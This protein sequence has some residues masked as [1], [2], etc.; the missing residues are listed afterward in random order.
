M[1]INQNPPKVFWDENQQPTGFFG[2]L[3]AEIGRRE[4]WD[5]DY[6]NCDWSECL[7]SLEKGDLDLMVDVSYSQKRDLRFDFNQEVVFPTWS[8]VYARQG[9]SLD[10]ILDLDGRK[11]AVL[12]G[13][14]Q[15]EALFSVTREFNI[16]PNFVPVA[17]YFEMSQLFEAGAIDGGVVNRFFPA[18]VSLKKARR[19]NILVKPTQ[20]HFAAPEGENADLL[21]AIDRHLVAMKKNPDSLYHQAEKRWLKGLNI[22]ANDWE[23]I[24]RLLWWA[25][26]VLVS[27]LLGLIIL[28]NYTLQREVHERIKAQDK[29]RHDAL[30]D[31]LTG[32]PNRNYLITYIKEALQQ[33]HTSPQHTFALLFIDLDRF[34]V[35]NDS[36]GHLVGDALLKEVA[37]RLSRLSCGPHVV[38]RLGGD[39]FVVLLQNVTSSGWATQAAADILKVLESPCQLNGHKVVVGGS[40]GIVF[41][42]SGYQQPAEIIQDA[43][44]A[45]YQAKA[46]RCGYVVFEPAMRSQANLRLQME[47]DLR[48]ALDRQEFVLHYQPILD[49]RSGDLIGFEALLRWQH[50]TRGLL[51]PAEFI[52][53][54]EETGLIVPLGWWV[55][56]QACGQLQRWRQQVPDFAGVGL[57]VN[58]SAVQLKE[59]RFIQQLDDIL[60][61]FHM[62]G[63][64]LTLELTE[65]LLVQDIDQTHQL[66]RAL[67][68]RCIDISIDDFGT[69]YS[70]LSYLHQL[71]I[72]TLKIDKAF[73][74]NLLSDKKQQRIVETML[75]LAQH[76]GLKVIAEGLENPIQKIYFHSHGCDY[77]QG[78]LFHP[79]LDAAAALEL[80]R[81]T[82]R[83]AV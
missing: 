35:V 21:A 19:T 57:S 7:E 77:G 4:D 61:E 50:P 48:R 47:S 79:P 69:G 80:L 44:I 5:I 81:Q 72:T 2:E 75:V 49:L 76:M 29:L 78:Y 8:V 53:I 51:A 40:I 25:G 3:I 41:G 52:G 15:H 6:I 23:Q 30:H 26:G 62:N 38:G 60:E 9:V 10:S 13:G 59:A 63:Q 54:A 36:L 28:W 70:S 24:R 33:V 73:T 45:M 68:T 31:G 43:D 56:R 1:G 14:I 66:L 12:A 39:E 16:T 20:V 42:G 65:S 18:N 11:I 67:Q 22:D 83:L 71:P 46:S 55:L 82:S 64:Q 58:V 34:K 74:R 37:W 17:D 27:S 32:L